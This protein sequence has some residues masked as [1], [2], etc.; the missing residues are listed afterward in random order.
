[1]RWVRR[2]FG[3]GEGFLFHDRT[4]RPP[5]TLDREFQAMGIDPKELL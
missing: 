1:L 2:F 3:E 5:L 4:I